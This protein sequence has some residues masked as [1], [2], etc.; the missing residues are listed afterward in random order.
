MQVCFVGGDLT[1]FNVKRF[2][3]DV[4]K[5]DIS[6]NSIS[7]L[8]GLE[9]CAE[10]LEE[11]ILDNNQLEWIEI[12]GIFPKLHTISINK[13]KVNKFLPNFVTKKIA[14]KS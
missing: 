11:L 6:Y 9:I 14:E 5:I 3:Q 12:I 8:K 4:R 2:G 7:K 13:N 1:E 10:Y